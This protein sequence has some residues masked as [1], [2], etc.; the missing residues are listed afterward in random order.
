MN[1]GRK[2]LPKPAKGALGKY[3]TRK[4]KKSRRKEL[5]KKEPVG[6]IKALTLRANLLKNIN[7]AASGKMR[8]DAAAI[9]KSRRK[10]RKSKK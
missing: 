8:K 7:P 3:S 10:S 4:S 2:L 1:K 6:T 5:S 9:K